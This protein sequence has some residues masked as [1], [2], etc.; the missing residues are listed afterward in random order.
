MNTILDSR[1]LN[2]PY[3]IEKKFHQNIKPEKLMFSHKNAI[4]R[5]LYS[6]VVNANRNL[7]IPG[8]NYVQLLKQTGNTCVNYESVSDNREAER[9]LITTSRIT[10]HLAM[11]SMDRC[12]RTVKS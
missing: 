4:F 11:A 6:I 2:G 10:L 7:A 12:C 8:R 3:F 1:A 5:S 9:L